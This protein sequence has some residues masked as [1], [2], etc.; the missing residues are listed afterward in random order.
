MGA[1]YIDRLRA[2]DWEVRVVPLDV[3]RALVEAYHYT[4]GA[5]NTATYVHGL[6]PR[7]SVWLADV[8]GVAWWIPPTKSAAVATYPARW[9]GV[10]SLS[11]LVIAP[12]VPKNACSF[13]LARS[14]ALIDRKA[15][16]C[17]VTYADEGQ[18]HTGTIYRATNWREVGRTAPEATFVIGARQVSRKA[19][20]KT[21]TRAEMT[22]LGARCIGRFARRKFVH[23]VGR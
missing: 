4:H 15:W 12:G 20:G 10:L 13:L 16:P 14:M 8:V 23:C 3:A 9:Q 21:R 19:G 22:A 6:C 17:L 18:G 5:S 7:E 2:A 11:R 1:D